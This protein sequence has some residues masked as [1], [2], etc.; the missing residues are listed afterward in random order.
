MNEDTM[1]KPTAAARQSAA[2]GGSV[3]GAA[4]PGPRPDVSFVELLNMLL[5][6]WRL[7]IGTP[8]VVAFL[9]AGSA[10]LGTRTYTATAAFMPQ[11]SEST[12]SGSGLGQLGLASV[13]LGGR[14]SN[15]GFY[16]ELL[17]TQEI[18]HAAATTEYRFSWRGEAHR[19]TLLDHLNLELRDAPGDRKALVLLLEETIKVTTTPGGIVE[20]EVTTP[21]A[22]LSEQVAARLLELV[23]EFDM[24]RRQTQGSVERKFTEE[25]L[26]EAEALLA[27]TQGALARFMERNRDFANSPRLMVESNQL[28]RD[29][30]VQ[31]QAYLTL[32]ELYERARIEEIRNTPVITIIDNP[33]GFAKRDSK[34][35]VRFGI[36]GLLV[37]G[38]LGVFGAIFADFLRTAR[39]SR[40][41]DVAELLELGGRFR[42]ALRRGGR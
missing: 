38:V 11:G 33:A 24:Q 7:V 9:M 35:T 17:T 19:G 14:G 26:R 30:A 12:Q 27:E 32:K 31:Q 13:L 5:R 3:A 1:V 41:S 40:R 10:F 42:G 2:P 16:G 39:D 4:T 21:Y 23:G 34:G 37:G 36:I 18:L 8:M 15:A 25:R 22:P 28:Q 29:V 6:S 20:V